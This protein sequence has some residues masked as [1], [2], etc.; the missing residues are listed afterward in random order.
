MVGKCAG[1]KL[2]AIIMRVSYDGIVPAL[3][4]ECLLSYI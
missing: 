1:A 4:L 2:R 3:F